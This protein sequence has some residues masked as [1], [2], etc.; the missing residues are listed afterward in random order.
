MIGLER[1]RLRK[2]LLVP[3]IAVFAAAFAGGMLAVRGSANQPP[4]PGV[5]AG[6]SALERLPAASNLP[7]QVVRFVEFAATA[8]ATNPEQA[9][10]RVR[11]LRS[12]LGRTDA[13]LYA[14]RTSGGATCFVLVGEVG[15]C[16]KSADDGSP[17]LQWTIGG[18]HDDV[19]SSLVGIASDDVTRVDLA[20]DGTDI[21]VSL[22]NNVAFAEYPSTANQ[23]VI[24]IHRMD[25]S[26]TTV[27]V[28]LEP[29]TANRELRLLRTRGE[30]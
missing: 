6:V 18:G 11:R 10:A 7:P 9:K 13:D 4:P 29:A 19:P 26:Q 22:R 21:P 5:S 14:F 28:R 27:Q 15:A 17:G 23:A 16:P 8:R 20:V 1:L 30:H 24:T 3:A 25:G 2:R 12:H